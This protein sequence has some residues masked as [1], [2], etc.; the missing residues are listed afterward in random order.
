[1]RCILP[2]MLRPLHKELAVSGDLPLR[3]KDIHPEEIY[4]LNLKI[5]T[6]G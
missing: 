2:T 5:A 4:L 6:A 1:M 3:E